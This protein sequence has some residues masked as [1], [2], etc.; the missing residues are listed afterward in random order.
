MIDIY[1]RPDPATAFTVSG[2]FGNPFSSAFDGIT[3]ETIEKKLYLRNDDSLYHYENISIQ[4]IDSGD[5]IVDGSG[6]TA[7]YS[8][9]MYAGDQ[10]PL[11][12]QWQLTDA[13][14]QI[15]LSDIGAPGTPDTST[16]LPFWVRIQVPRGAPVNSYSGVALRISFD[17]SSV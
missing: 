16:Y 10:Q 15:T 17:Q 5:N 13:G 11:E 14:N 12:E 3:G 2:D 7:G 6:A 1:E 9:K 8:W 4:P